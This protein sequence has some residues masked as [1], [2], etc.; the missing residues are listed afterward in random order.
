M[1]NISL[2][3]TV[4]WFGNAM[5]ETLS[6]EIESNPIPFNLKWVNHSAAS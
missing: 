1:I 3:K 5:L 2:D 6:K 4:W